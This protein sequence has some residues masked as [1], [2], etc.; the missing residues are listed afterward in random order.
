[1]CTFSFFV[2]LSVCL[3]FCFYVC[4]SH[5]VGRSRMKICFASA[6][7]V[8]CG[9][10]IIFDMLQLLTTP[11]VP[12]TRNPRWE[13][14]AEFFI[15]DF[16]QV[17]FYPVLFLCLFLGVSLALQSGW[18]WFPLTLFVVACAVFCPHS[19]T[20]KRKVD[21]SVVPYPLHCPTPCHLWCQF[22]LREC[23]TP[24]ISRDMFIVKILGNEI[25]DSSPKSFSG[26]GKC[27][28]TPFDP[29]SVSFILRLQDK[30]GMSNS[31][32]RWCPSNKCLH[33][34][35]LS[36]W[37]LLYFNTSLSLF[38]LVYCVEACVWMICNCFFR[39]KKILFIHLCFTK[40]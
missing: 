23:P 4:L 24:C 2:C 16:T 29:K 38:L 25:G 36:L 18:I 10:I 31:Y 35:Q 13:S 21:R 6:D 22:V 7:T 37:C 8:C 30:D 39:D 20:G 14:W 9:L 19:I 33:A 34:N 5:W 3:C 1:M 11:Y 12:A 26:S 17:S 15:G 40:F 32:S 27:S 28:A